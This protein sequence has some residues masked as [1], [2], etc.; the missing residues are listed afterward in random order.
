MEQNKVQNE[1]EIELDKN[2]NREIQLDFVYPQI[3]DTNRQLNVENIPSNEKDNNEDIIVVEEEG[4]DDQIDKNKER[5]HNIYKNDNIDE[6]NIKNATSNKQL[7][8]L[9]LQQNN[10]PRSPDNPPQQKN[11][12][13]N[14]F[15]FFEDIY[16]DILFFFINPIAGSHHGQLLIDMGVKKVEFLDNM[17]SSA[18]SA[19]IF[20]ILDQDN[21]QQGIALL[22]DYQERGKGYFYRFSSTF[23][24]ESNYW[25]RRWNDTESD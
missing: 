6:H 11:N 17:K 18:Y 8:N 21:Y 25:R 24:T 19:Y 7:S 9:N 13:R 16:K 20:N 14:K 3:F 15:L 1:K 4:I 12:S 2:S 23:S 5:E 22:K 10:Y